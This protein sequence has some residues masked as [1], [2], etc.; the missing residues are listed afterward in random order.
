MITKEES[1]H[2]FSTMINHELLEIMD[3]KFE[4]TEL[5]ILVALQELSKRNLSEEYIFMQ[6]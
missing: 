6:L 3:R 4:H 2:N 5:A 1:E